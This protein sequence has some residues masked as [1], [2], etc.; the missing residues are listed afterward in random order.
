MRSGIYTL[1][2]PLL[3]VLFLLGGARL[4]AQTDSLPKVR[5]A[6]VVPNAPGFDMYLDE[7]MPAVFQ[8]INFG[9]ASRNFEFQAGQHEATI[10]LSGAPKEAALIQQQAFANLDTAYT[11]V[12]T[13][14]LVPFDIAPVVLTRSLSRVPPSGQT[15]IRLLH[16]SLPAGTVDVKVT[17]IAS[18]TTTF[19]GVSFRSASN[20]FA[21]PSGNIRVEISNP[22]EAPFYIGT[23]SVTQGGILTL[24]AVGRP[25][26]DSSSGTFKVFVLPDNSDQAKTPMDTLRTEQTGTE[27]LWRFINV[28]PT[29]P[30]LVL[31]VGSDTGELDYRF[32]SEALDLEAGT[33]TL[34]VWRPEDG[35]PNALIEQD[36]EV[37]ANAYRATYVIGD[38]DA[39][40]TDILSLTADPTALP[41]SGQTSVRLLNVALDTA[42]VDI[43]MKFSNGS[44]RNVN[45]SGF[46]NFTQYAFAPAGETTVTLT[47]PGESAPFLTAKG[48]IPPNSYG[49]IIVLGDVRDGGLR[50]N[51]LVDSRKSEQMPMTEFQ[52][53]TGVE[54]LR[55]LVQQFRLLRDQRSQSV[56]VSYTLL[57]PTPLAVQ[58][59][60]L[61]GGL[62]YSQD[63]GLQHTGE[64]LHQIALNDLP[65]GYY[66]V[67]IQSQGRVIGSEELMIRN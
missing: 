36:V 52:I 14:E 20:Y 23:G 60:D 51:L 22:G 58:I 39:G 26:S 11:I 59:H 19:S 5:V 27:G 63:L 8:G 44:V 37:I 46:R 4:V 29:E 64:H 10:T 41:P 18:N 50:V 24:I 38:P 7:I 25:N 67:S 66:L 12:A 53:T 3:L 6:H 1:L 35:E 16:A 54:S 49:T 55:Q 32:A 62:R 13:G 40:T 47:R 33:Y 34:K 61:R 15:F 57:E 28:V 2:L 43:Q 30:K 31:R 56:R 21:V 65:S 42:L 48:T 17:D 9:D 45:S